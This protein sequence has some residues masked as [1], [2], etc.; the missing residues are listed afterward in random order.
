MKTP[1]PR[2][3]AT[4]LAALVLSLSGFA[5]G[6]AAAQTDARQAEKPHDAADSARIQSLLARQPEHDILD[7]LAGSWEA[8]LTAKARGNPPREMP[9]PATLE[10]RWILDRYFLESDE[11]FQPDG[12]ATI[13]SRCIYGYNPLKKHFYRTVFQGGDPREYVSTGT[14]NAATRT[15]TFLGPE[16]AITGDA[17]QRRDT[18]RLIGEDQIAYEL[19]FLFQN[20]SEIQAVQGTY[21]RKDAKV[22]Q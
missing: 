14:W 9:S 1:S 15:L 20:G 22:S 11:T 10:I 3:R 21:R 13:R 16:N 18:F 8:T 17:F 7:A 4:V 6:R 5:A 19:A 2:R 12:K